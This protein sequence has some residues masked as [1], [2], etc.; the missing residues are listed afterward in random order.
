MSVYTSISDTEFSE[1]LKTYSLG[2][3]IASQGI[4]AGIE[5]TNYFVSTTTGEYIFTLFEKINLY[6]RVFSGITKILNL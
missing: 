1:I 2:D 4:Q 5:N 3:F 6:P